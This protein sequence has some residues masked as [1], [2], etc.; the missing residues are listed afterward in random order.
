MG[1]WL[2]DH[3]PES[4]AGVAR[5][6][7]IRIVGAL[8]E[9]R[10][11]AGC[12]GPQVPHCST[13]DTDGHR[14]LR[15]ILVRDDCHNGGESH[16]SHVA[17]GDEGISRGGRCASR[18]HYRGKLGKCRQSICAEKSEALNCET[19]AVVCFLSWK[20]ATEDVVRVEARGQLVYEVYE[21]AVGRPRNEALAEILAAVKE[22]R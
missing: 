11:G 2:S 8:R 22:R 4:E 9:R 7:G 14:A 15:M 6:C 10:N 12:I 21:L 3:E 1:P 16:L 20:A 19:A 5:E 18:I 17:Y 13:Y